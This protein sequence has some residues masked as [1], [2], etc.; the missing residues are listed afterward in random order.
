V[1]KDTGISEASIVRFCRSIGLEGFADLKIQLIKCISS[2][3]IP[4][5]FEE[6]DETESMESVARNVFTRNLVTLQTAMQ[7]MDFSQ[8]AAAS[9]LIRQATRIV[10]CGLGVSASI[11]D[12]CYVHLFRAGLP[13][14]VSTDPELMQIFARKATEGT[15]FLAISKGGRSTA[16]I[17]ALQEAQLH[18]AKTISI[19]AH[20]KTPLTKVS[21]ISLVHY[22]PTRAMVSTRVVQNTIV[23]CL[24][25][26]ATR[27]KQQDVINQ[28]LENRRVADFLR[29][30]D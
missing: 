26:C 17:N 16:V 10:V 2:Q 18:G 28:I 14:I 4:S 27:Y 21:D 20:D 12:N 11:A 24:Y 30:S 1:A 19:T 15:V 8:I 13:A 23:D 3:P 29:S 7:Q 25:I 5:V 9:D 6:I 22:A